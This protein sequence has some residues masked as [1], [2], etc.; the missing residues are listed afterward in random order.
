MSKQNDVLIHWGRAY[1][2][3]PN[4]DIDY[5]SAALKKFGDSVQDAYPEI[6][7][8]PEVVAAE[9]YLYFL[10]ERFGVTPGQALLKTVHRD[11]EFISFL[12]NMMNKHAVKAKPCEQRCYVAAIN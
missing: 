8:W 11:Q 5:S 9:A 2:S 12:R 1:R 4:L 6:L 10:S 3:I 7:I